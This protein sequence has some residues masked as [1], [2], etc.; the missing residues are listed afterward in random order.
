MKHEVEILAQE[1]INLQSRLTAKNLE[2]EEK[3]KETSISKTPK[4]IQTDSQPTA[5]SEA[6]N[7]EV[8]EMLEKLQTTHQNEVETLNSV[9]R[10]LEKTKKEFMKT[11]KVFLKTNYYHYRHTAFCLEYHPLSF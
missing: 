9:I 8:Q 2:H 6:H 11:F 10:E 4:G 7:A 5:E 3:M 1:V